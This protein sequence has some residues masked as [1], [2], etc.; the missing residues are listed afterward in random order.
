[1]K[2]K[3]TFYFFLAA[4]ILLSCGRN[5]PSGL[6]EFVSKDGEVKSFNFISDSSVIISSSESGLALTIKYR[7]EKNFVI[8]NIPQLG[9]TPVEI[10]NGGIKTTIG[11]LYVKKTSSSAP[12]VKSS[13]NNTSTNSESNDQF[14]EILTK[15]YFQ[16]SNGLFSLITL[17]FTSKE[18]YVMKVIALGQGEVV[19]VRGKFEVVSQG[20]SKAHI[21]LNPGPIQKSSLYDTFDKF[22]IDYFITS[23]ITYSLRKFMDTD[24]EKFV[25]ENPVI[26]QVYHDKKQAP[27][28]VLDGSIVFYSEKYLTQAEKDSIA[29]QQQLEKKKKDKLEE[30]LKGL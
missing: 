20:D 7:I 24:L 17:E 15:N 30:K 8:M 25:N 6:Y 29:N 11:E 19:N 16:K 23:N 14:F 9:E 5:K 1:M 2:T 26:A 10:T 13:S 21:T 27:S 3:I 18:D 28:F 4:F 12:T 22:D